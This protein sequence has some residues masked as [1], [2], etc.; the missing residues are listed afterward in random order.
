MEYNFSLFAG[1]AVQLYEATLVADDTPYDRAVGCS[2]ADRQRGS[3][4]NPKPVVA[5]LSALP[6]PPAPHAI[7]KTGTA[8]VWDWS[9][10]PANVGG[11]GCHVCHALGE[12][13]EHSTRR[14][15]DA[16]GFA[17]IA[18]YI[19]DGH[20]GGGGSTNYID[21]GMRNVGHRPFSEDALRGGTAP[22]LPPFQYK[23]QVDGT[24]KSLPLSYA[25][26]WKLTH[27]NPSRIT[28]ALKTYLL[29]YMPNA[30]IPVGGALPPASLDNL[31]TAGCAKAPSL[32]TS[33]ISGGYFHDGAYSTL[34]QVVDA[35]ARGLNYPQ[36]NYSQLAG[37]ILPIEQLDP[38]DSGRSA[39]T[40]P[41]LPVTLSR[42]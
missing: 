37:G 39:R 21:F 17:T 28:D 5:D 7:A 24:V 22:A 1:L 13:T 10:A 20:G 33:L 8:T 16:N 12:F 15:L 6:D 30:P 38:T 34:R 41:F 25:E 29:G 36:T 40:V 31:A 3:P 27:E 32:R 2:I 42:R 9:P 4:G 35:Y 18:R 19:A 14:V 11:V 26:L 23:D